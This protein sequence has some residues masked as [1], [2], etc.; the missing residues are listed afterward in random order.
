MIEAAG[1]PGEYR[2]T[3]LAAIDM[4]AIA[5]NELA[6][7]MP[8]ESEHGIDTRSIELLIGEVNE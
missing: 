5:E 6:Y 7:L 2:Q 3:L 8:P 4:A 1:N